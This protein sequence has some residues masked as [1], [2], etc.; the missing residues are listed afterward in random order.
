[1]KEATRGRPTEGNPSATK[2]TTLRYDRHLRRT[3]ATVLLLLQGA[4]SGA[5]P[6]EPPTTTAHDAASTD[7]A[8]SEGGPSRDAG[9]SDAGFSEAGTSDGGTSDG[10]TSD[11]STSDG[12][13]SDG[14]TS[15]TDAHVAPEASVDAAGGCFLSTVGVFGQ[16]ITTADCTALGEHTSTAGFCPGAPPDVECCT[17]TPNVADNPPVPAGWVLMQ[18]S[19]VA[20]AMTAWAV[21]ILDDPTTYPMYSTTIQTFGTL[22]VLAR[23]EWH[24]P[25]FQNATVH[26]GVTLYQPV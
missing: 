26:R 11:G 2:N 12:S 18:E 7:G 3:I 25:D 4:C 9:T 17:T 13:A 1:M 15:T 10:S 21:M 23:V 5:S 20:P 24:P 22:M 6:T 8:D 14:N 16:C 19:A